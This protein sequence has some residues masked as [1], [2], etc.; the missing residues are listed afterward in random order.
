MNDLAG[1]ANEKLTNTA[2][3]TGGNGSAKRC[4][5]CAL[6]NAAAAY[7]C[8]KCGSF[9]KGNGAALT[10]GLRR[11]QQTGVLPADLRVSVEEFRATLISD[12]GGLDEL[13]AVRAGLCRLLVDAEVGRR[14]LMN[15]VVRAGVNTRPGR[16][17]YDRLLATMDRWHRVASTLG[18]E[19]RAKPALTPHEYWKQKVAARETETA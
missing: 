14:L 1:A 9:L 5:R 8:A 7:Q 2:T 17:A 19:R 6:D 3:P 12:Q 10:H 11:Y 15:E 4:A 13:T 18:T 16:A